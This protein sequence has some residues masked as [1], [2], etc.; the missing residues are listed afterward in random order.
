MKAVKKYDEGGDMPLN[1]K[2]LRA[3]QRKAEKAFESGDIEK[4]RELSAKAD[5]IAKRQKKWKDGIDRYVAEQDRRS[6]LNAKERA[7]S[8]RTF[9]SM[10]SLMDKMHREQL[11]WTSTGGNRPTAQTVNK[12]RPKASTTKKTK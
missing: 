10:D 6:A 4:A 3:I 2:R 12:P 5:K 11:A 8:S 1:Q 7:R 9:G